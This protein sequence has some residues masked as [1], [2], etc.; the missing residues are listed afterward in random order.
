M[1]QNWPWGSQVADEKIIEI[2]QYSLHRY[3][4]IKSHCKLR[5]ATNNI[6]VF[7]FIKYQKMLMSAKNDDFSTFLNTQ[8]AK[9]ES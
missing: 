7:A 6:I 5:F 9:K 8:I 1:A 2:Q 3:N 4:S